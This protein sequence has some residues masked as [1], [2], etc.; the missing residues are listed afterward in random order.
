MLGEAQRLNVEGSVGI[1]SPENFWKYRYSEM[2]SGALWDL[3]DC[4][5][6]RAVLY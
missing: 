6:L 5:F 4:Y 3:G 1:P 2:H